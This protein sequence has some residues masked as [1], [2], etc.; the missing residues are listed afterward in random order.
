MSVRPN[1]VGLQSPTNSN[2]INNAARSKFKSQRHILVN[3]P[4]SRI[5]NGMAEFAL[6]LIHGLF[7][8]LSEYVYS[9]SKFTTAF[10]DD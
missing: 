10:L 2:A 4:P 7:G 6:S 1:V 9:H 5:G 8:E 3:I